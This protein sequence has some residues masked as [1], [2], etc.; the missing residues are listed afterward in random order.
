MCHRIGRKHRML[1]HRLRRK[2]PRQPM[3]IDRRLHRLATS[4]GYCASIAA[5]IPVRISPLPPFA[6]EDSR[7]YSPPSVPSGCATSVRQPF[8]TSVT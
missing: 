6:I 2:V 8:N 3:Q 4:S 1:I 7:S 5:T